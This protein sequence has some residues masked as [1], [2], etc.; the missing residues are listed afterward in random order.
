MLDS[1]VWLPFSELSI[2]PCA[3]IVPT[4][5]I[6]LDD[7]RF[8]AVLGR[9]HFGKVLLAESKKTKKFYALKTLKKAEILY[10][11]EIDTL[12]SEKRIFQTITEA[13]HPFLVNLVAC[14]Q[15]SV[16]W[17]WIVQLTILSEFSIFSSSPIHA[18]IKLD[19]HQMIRG[20]SIKL[21]M[22]YRLFELIIVTFQKNLSSH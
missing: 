2:L 5:Q 7:F 17:C 1:V 9:G 10:R 19:N 14:F 16:S 13:R 11:N 18:C 3:S 22:Q 20:L 12:I 8:V 21:F 6:S 15:T 4:E